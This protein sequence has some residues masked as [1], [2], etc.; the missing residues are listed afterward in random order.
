MADHE[1]QFKFDSFESLS[2]LDQALAKPFV[3]ASKEHIAAVST[4]ASA[5]LAGLK[6]TLQ[7]ALVQYPDFPKEGIT[8]ED[9]MPLFAHPKLH[10]SLNRALHLMIM[11]VAC[12]VWEQGKPPKDFPDVIVGLESRGF[13]IGPSVAL[14]FGAAFVP[15]RKYGKL[16]GPCH[17]V[18]YKKEYGD[19][20]FQMQEG[21]IKP[22]Q[23]VYILDDIIATGKT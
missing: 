6:V 4:A 20:R 10:A 15:V 11:N 21:V 8:F 5:E 19:D 14:K 18:G 2:S 12:K 16:P 3:N 9:I 22:G 23:S 13:L 1:C 7:N 17:T